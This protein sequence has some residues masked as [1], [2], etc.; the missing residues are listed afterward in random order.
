MHDALERKVNSLGT[1]FWEM[2][3]SMSVGSRVPDLFQS[4]G[5]KEREEAV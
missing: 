4:K 5:K 3:E 1:V 2:P